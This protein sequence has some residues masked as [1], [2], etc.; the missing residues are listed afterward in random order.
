[1]IS[2]FTNWYYHLIPIRL[3]HYLKVWLF[4]IYDLFSVNIIFK[5]FFAPWKRDII[6]T[7]N[8]TLNEKIRVWWMNLIARGVGAFI[9]TATLIGFLISFI[10]WLAASIIFVIGW[11]LFPIIFILIWI[12]I[13]NLL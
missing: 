10:G 2:I 1:M 3:F 8:L 6:S 7:K 9:K 4:H 11:F 12:G 13:S 5:T